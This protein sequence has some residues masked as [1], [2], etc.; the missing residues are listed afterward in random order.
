M[1][2]FDH[3][4]RERA[5]TK[6][7]FY[8]LTNLTVFA[9]LLKDVPMGCKESVLPEPLLKNQNVSCPT[10][11]QNTQKP[12]KDNL[13]LFRALALHLHGNER[14]DEETSKIFNLFLNNC[15]EAV[16]SKFQ[17]AHMTYVPKWEEMLKLNIFP[18]DIDFVDGELIGE[19]AQRSI[20]KFKESVKRLCYNNQIC[21]VS[22]MNSFFKSFR[23]STCDT[24]FSKTGNLERHL[25]TCSE[26]VKH[27]YPKNLYQLRETLFEK[28]DTFNIP[29]REDQKLFKNWAIFAFES[30]CVK[31]ETYQETETAKWIGK[32]VPISV[33]ISSNLIPEPI[34]FAIQ[35]LDTMYLLL[36]VILKA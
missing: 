22:D 24:T 5:N 19:L 29:Y 35:I 20:Q 21:C 36:L 30:I 27:I 15:G 3:C 25:I 18:Y 8:K 34:F 11:E 12:Y 33:S 6:W 9:A 31:E 16:P 13:C 32:H 23:C 4:T 7:T 2:L 14:L 1:V 28:L 17:D 10:Y 26:R